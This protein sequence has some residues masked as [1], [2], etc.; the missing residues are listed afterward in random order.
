METIKQ[1]FKTPNKWHFINEL[2][3]GKQI[4]IKMFVGVNET[5]VQIFKINGLYAN[6]GFNYGKKT[7]TLKALEAI[8]LS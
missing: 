5:D 8:I 6:I 4:Q 3:N 2:I 7:K 1:A